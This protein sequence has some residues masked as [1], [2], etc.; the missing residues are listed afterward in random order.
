MRMA[1]A[2]QI[3]RSILRLVFWDC[4]NFCRL[5]RIALIFRAQSW[6]M[7]RRLEAVMHFGL[8]KSRIHI[9]CPW[10]SPLITRM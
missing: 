2:C 8:V 3:R 1:G 10:D 7:C 5:P 6:M 4:D 9:I